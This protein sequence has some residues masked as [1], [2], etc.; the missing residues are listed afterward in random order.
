M[1]LK[2]IEDFE[3]NPHFE[4]INCCAWGV[5]HVVERDMCYQPPRFHPVSYTTGEWGG[6]VRREKERVTLDRSI[7]LWL[8]PFIRV[9]YSRINPATLW[10][11]Q[12]G[13]KNLQCNA[14]SFQV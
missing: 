7:P 14:K 12:K 10:K 1:K 13:L 6:I 5:K 4:R 11:H 3:L 9:N 2:Y 8:I